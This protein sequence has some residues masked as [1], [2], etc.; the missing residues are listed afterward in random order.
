MQF[1][2]ARECSGISWQYKDPMQHKP[3]DCFGPGAGASSFS[4]S[5]LNA[6]CTY[7]P[8]ALIT[9][10]KYITWLYM[11]IWRHAAFTAPY[12]LLANSKCEKVA[13]SRK[14]NADTIHS[15]HWILKLQFKKIWPTTHHAGA[16]GV[17]S[18]SSYL[19]STSALDGV[20]RQS[21]APAAR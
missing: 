2:G 4:L 3:P 9:N 16:W 14:K 20:S 21:H 1:G 10:A 5:S 19:F 8:L 12:W 11:D 18:Y 7:L 13:F 17:R 15:V 6:S